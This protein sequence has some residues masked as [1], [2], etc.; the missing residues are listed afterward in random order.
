MLIVQYRAGEG[1]WSRTVRPATQDTCRGQLLLQQIMMRHSSYSRLS[2]ENSEREDLN[3]SSGPE[4][5]GFRGREGALAPAVHRVFPIGLL[6]T[7]VTMVEKTRRY[8]HLLPA[9]PCIPFASLRF[10][11][12]ARQE[13]RSTHASHHLM[14]TRWKGSTARMGDSSSKLF[15][16]D[17]TCSVCKT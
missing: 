3:A 7:R 12:A 13:P 14:Q 8:R 17:S 2:F 4:S 1:Y 11:S 5:A 6:P 15:R 10:K 9:L 16:S